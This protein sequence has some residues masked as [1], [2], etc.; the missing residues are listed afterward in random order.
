[1]K[2][3][4]YVEEI[5]PEK[6]MIE[7]VEE[8]KWDE[9][10]KIEYEEKVKQEENVKITFEEYVEVEGDVKI[11]SEEEEIKQ[12]EEMKIEYVNVKMENEYEEI[13]DNLTDE[14]YQDDDEKQ[15]ETYSKKKDCSLPPK[16]LDLLKVDKGNIFVVNL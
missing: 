7:Y 11:E 8:V 10:A 6:N 12:E 1:M 9:D 13:C 3:Y 14:R 2:D 15:D 16:R 5:K 4:K